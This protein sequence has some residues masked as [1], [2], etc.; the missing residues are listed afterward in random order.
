MDTDAFIARIT[1]DTEPVR[2][3]VSPWLRTLFWIALALPPLVLVIAGHG[4]GVGLDTI[5][6]DQRL[7]V[8]EIA[9]LAT[10]VSA[11]VAAFAS[12]VPGESRKWL[13]IP[14]VPLAVWL[15]AIGKGCLDD[16]LRLG[17]EGL[18]LRLDTGCLLPMIL[19]SIVPAVTMVVMLRRGAPLSP[20]L[21]LALG[22]LATAAIVNFGLR[23]FHVGDISLMVLVWHFGLA[24]AL[25][26]FAGVVA[27]RILAWRQGP[28]AQ[29]ASA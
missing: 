6:G 15:L 21:T 13:W 11:A 16:F 10:A 23:L 27:P 3:L 2:R 5:L 24:A 20:R 8:E 28:L 19:I 25:S 26:A 1:E 22:A 7:I 12:T 4:L 18:S 29:P 17:S 14:V 9:V